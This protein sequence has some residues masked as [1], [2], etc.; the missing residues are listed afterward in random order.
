MP[1]RSKVAGPSTSP[2]AQD[3]ISALESSSRPSAAVKLRPSKRAG[4]PPTAE[5]SRLASSLFGTPASNDGRQDERKRRRLDALEQKETGREHVLDED[6]FT[7]EGVGSESELEEE[8]ERSGDFSDDGDDHTEATELED[9]AAHGESDHEAKEGGALQSDSDSAEEGEE[10]DPRI[11]PTTTRRPA[12][13]DSALSSLQVALAGPSARAMD[14]SF[15]GTK[16]LRKLRNDPDETHV[17]GVEYERRL[18][19]MYERLHP[20]PAWAKPAASASNNVTN[21]ALSSLLSKAGTLVRPTK[22]TKQAPLPREKIQLR[23]ARDANQVVTSS[24]GQDGAAALAGI[25]CI[26]W[27]P[28]TRT[29]LML[30]ASRDRIV[31]L[32]EIDGTTNP[33]LQSLS[34]PSLPLTRASFHPSGSSILLAGPRPYLYAYDLQSGRSIRS[35]PWRGGGAHSD[36]DSAERDLS[37]A[38]FQ[39]DRATGGSGRLLAV[40][41]RRGAVHL[42]DWGSGSSG[43]G[44]AGGGGAGLASTLRSNSAVCGMSWDQSPSA[45]GNRLLTLNQGGTVHVWDVRSMRA[46][47]ERRDVDLFAPKGLEGNCDATLWAA[48][49]EGGV[50]SIY[51]KELAKVDKGQ[52]DAAHI[53]TVSARKTIENLKT[54]ITSMKWNHD[55]SVLALASRNVKDALRLVHAPTLTAFSNWPTSSTPLG[56]VTDLAFSNASEYLAVA[57]SRGKVLLYALSH[58]NA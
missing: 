33:L 10:S 43:G 37:F 51:D 28:S 5:E 21:A 1:K 9:D 25:E 56:H 57:N 12:W 8:K 35:T 26:D 22:Q 41:G 3:E 13:T 32:F 58:Y 16:R 55:G 47:V 30:T 7:I 17:S 34:V 48:G 40:G 38:R 6:L 45:G 42:L 24:A 54:S 46:Q 2:E 39:P 53:G 36:A 44:A 18:R 52:D 29:R 14:G 20:R 11:L 31:R 19:E 23:R 4:L 15:V 49:S 50:V 27:H